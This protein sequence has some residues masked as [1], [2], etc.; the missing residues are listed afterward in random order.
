MMLLRAV[1]LALA[2]SLSG[3]VAAAEGLTAVDSVGIP[4]SD[5]DRAEAFYAQVLGFSKVSEHEI[6]GEA[7][8]HL[9]GVFGLRLR[10][11]RM[12]LGDEAIEL[13]RRYADGEISLDELGAAIAAL[14]DS[15]YGPVPISGNGRP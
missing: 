10:I 6:T 7:Y 1:L 2:A 9:F 13:Y 5:L 15:R 14:H 8:E 4:V 3:A 11:A 12:R